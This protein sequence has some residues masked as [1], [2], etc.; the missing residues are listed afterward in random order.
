MPCGGSLSVRT[1]L[2]DFNRACKAAT[3]PA[4]NCCAPVKREDERPHRL[5][6]SRVPGMKL[7]SEESSRYTSGVDRGIV[8]VSRVA[9]QDS[10]PV[11]SSFNGRTVGSE[12]I[13]R[14][15]NPWEATN[16]PGIWTRANRLQLHDFPIHGPS[17]P[18]RGRAAC[19]PHAK[20]A[21]STSAARSNGSR[22]CVNATVP[23]KF[24]SKV[25]R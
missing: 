24:V 17:V 7:T 16:H 4:N 10:Y 22:G 20:F 11:A 21:R 8:S 12:P 3:R 19:R 9:K 23:K 1:V 13:N 5:S 15:S 18:V 2:V 6:I 25:L 14:G